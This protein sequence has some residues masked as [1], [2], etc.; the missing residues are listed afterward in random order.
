MLDNPNFY[1][2]L[3]IAIGVI[4]MIVQG[5]LQ[6]VFGKYSKIMFHGGLTGREVAEKMLR[7]NGIHDVQVTS[8]RGHLTDNYNPRTKT[9]NLSESVYNSNSVAAAAVAAH[10]CGHAI[11]DATEY[12]PLKMRAALVPVIS[13][14]SKWSTW[15]I[16][17]GAIIAGSTGNPIILWIGIGLVAMSALFSIVTLPVEYNASSRALTWLGSSNTLSQEEVAQASVPLKWAARTYLVAA[18][19]A[20]AVLLYWIAVAGRRN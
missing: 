17:L 5:R 9:V 4:G 19:S 3:I 11:Q 8:T 6:S 2:F 12:A 20:I 10:E 16:I 13:I 15:V 14:S 7:D 1:W 18:L